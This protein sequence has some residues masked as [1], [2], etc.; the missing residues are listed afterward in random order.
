MTTIILAIVIGL[1]L[2]LINAAGG[3][4]YGMSKSN[5]VGGEESIGS[6]FMEEGQEV[7]FH[8]KRKL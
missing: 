4:V 6:D 3:T 1:V 8:D 2:G 7:E 5:V